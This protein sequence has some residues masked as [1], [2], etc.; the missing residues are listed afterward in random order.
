MWFGFMHNNMLNDVSLV[1]HC[2]VCE[3]WI[4][5]YFSHF[6]P[7]FAIFVKCHP[8]SKW[9]GDVKIWLIMTPCHC[10]YYPPNMSGQSFCNNQL[11]YII[12]M[13]FSTMSLYIQ[14]CWKHRI[15]CKL[16]RLSNDLFYD[17]INERIKIKLN[18]WHI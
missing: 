17:L 5:F 13:L 14:F 1:S 2:N 3:K 11:K 9:T 7:F 18:W 4:G 6:L 8:K 15:K 16:L 12:R 10:R